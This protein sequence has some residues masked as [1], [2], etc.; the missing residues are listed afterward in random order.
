[1]FVSQQPCRTADCQPGTAGT[2]PS[3]IQAT[4]FF[5][6]DP[7]EPGE[8]CVPFAGTPVLGSVSE[9]AC[10]E[11]VWLPGR[12]DVDVSFVLPEGVDRGGPVGSDSFAA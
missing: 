2:L 12:R 3:W 10:T 4:Y 7:F 9:G 5:E 1:M 6:F 8:S 11:P